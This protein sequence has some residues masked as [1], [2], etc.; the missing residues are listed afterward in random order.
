MGHSQQ[1]S[2]AAIHNARFLQTLA[3][4]LMLRCVQVG[5]MQGMGF[6]AGFAAAV[7]GS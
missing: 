2:F 5:C 4:Q 6:A 7:P 3:V 1:G